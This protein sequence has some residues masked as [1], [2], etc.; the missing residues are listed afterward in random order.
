MART[1]NGVDGAAEQ[2]AHD[3]VTAFV[4][5]H[6]RRMLGSVALIAGGRQEAEDALGEAVARAWDQ[7]C[8]GRQIDSLE[9]WVFV[10]ASNELRRSARRRRRR[11]VWM[12]TDLVVEDA[13]DL[14][15]T[16][17]GTAVRSLPLR[18]R[19]AIVLRYWFDLSIAET[20]VALGVAEGTVKAL[21]HQARS[22]LRSRLSTP[23]RAAHDLPR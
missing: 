2:E 10:V 3:R 20:A 22:S 19:Q 15:L 17:L 6:G 16:T 4:T 18:Q 23:E 7:L 13:P 9:A 11:P 1:L 14:G 8:R 12:P 21:L 5:D